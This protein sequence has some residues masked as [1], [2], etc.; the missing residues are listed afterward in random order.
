MTPSAEEPTSRLPAWA[1]DALLGAAVTVTLAVVISAGQGGRNEP[2]SFAYLWAAGLG[3]L[4]LARRRH[5]VLV[6]VIS[7]L[8][9]FSYYIAGYPAIGV[10]VPVAAA[11]LS[12]AEFGRLVWAVAAAAVVLAT[13]VGFRI[14]DGEEELS[15]VVGYDLAGHVL[16]M[17]AAIALGDSL[18]SRRLAAESTRRIVALTAERTRQQADAARREE[19]VAIARD[20]HDSLGH[21][22]SVVSMHADV[23]REA[24][25][26]GDPESAG[27][28]LR[29]IK[30]TT[31]ASM[32]ELRRTVGL[33]RTADRAPRSALSLDDLD[34]MT[35]TT[36]GVAVGTDVRI[37]RD[38]PASVDSAAYRI[39][40][41][42]VTNIVKHSTAT[43]ATVTVRDHDDVL[44]V[45]V[46][47]DG[48]PPDAPGPLGE[49]HGI[50]GMRERATT[51]G[52]TLEA[53]PVSDGFRVRAT[54]P[55]QEVP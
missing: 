15:Y 25:E 29:I 50:A 23:A 1:V 21:A 55:L 26:R 7:V 37:S 33:L 46:R 22:T 47:D 48:G 4:M 24:V 6:L 34:A 32:T 9:L 3:G 11:L 5:P 31:T 36:T 30:D 53:G 43:H 13:S 41:E 28:A 38:L 19:R 35:A 39:I 49:G 27:A 45:E 16:L 2:D 12:A 8:G 52:G 14:A 51:L 44:E 42:A 20:L 54:L 18:R 40:Q 10:A 17:S